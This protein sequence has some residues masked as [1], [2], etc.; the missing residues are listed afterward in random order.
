MAD[1]WARQI[2][3]AQPD[4]RRHICRGLLLTEAGRISAQS[5]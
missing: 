1:A 3:V 2:R 5:C 4:E